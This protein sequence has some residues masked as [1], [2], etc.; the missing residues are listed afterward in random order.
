MM[1]VRALGGLLVFNL[2][3]LG[4]GAGLLWGARGWRWWTDL[5]RLVGVAYLLGLSALMV[6]MTLEIVIGIPVALA[7]ILLNGFG[8]AALGVAAGR[9]RRLPLPGLRPP[10]WRFPGISVFEALFLAGIVVY[11]EG[12]FRADRLAGVAREWD[13]WAF[14]VP[15][16]KELYLSGR[17]GPDF[18]LL[19]EQG[20]SY[21][22][23]LA[24]IQAGAFHAMGSADTATLHVQYW[25]LALG[26]AAAVIGLFAQ[27]VHHAIVFPLLL[28]FLVAPSVLD[29]ITTVYADIP[30]GYLVAVAALLIVLWIEERESWQLAAATVLLS[31]AVLTKREG[32]LFAACLL[33]AAF[34]ASFAHRRQLWRRLFAAG[35]IVL[36]AALPWRIWFLAHDLPG[37]G[38]EAGYLGAFS[39]LERIWPSL[40]FVVATFFDEDLWSFAPVVVAAAIALALLARA[41]TVSLYAGAFLVVALVASGWVFWSNVS[42]GLNQDEW[43]VRRLTGTTLLVLAVLTPLLLQRAWS[44]AQLPRSSAAPLGGD[45]LLGRS[46]MAWAIVLVGVLSHPG[47]MLVGYSGSGLPGGLPSFPESGSCT[48]AP[49]AG[50]NVRVVLGYA[51]SYPEAHAMRRRVRAAGVDGVEMAQDGCGRVRVFVDVGSAADSE[52]LV[53]AVRSANLEPTLEGLGSGHAR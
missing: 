20:S 21:P 13:S 45:A 19:L 41:W 30:L 15:R 49:A 34:V 35:L 3:I 6:L 36:A 14:W 5:V 8:L 37:D 52:A 42:L 39:N 27:R 24:T 18:L 10:G 23:G 12:L 32:V 48:S 51:G 11:F 25:F 7:T 22:P 40:R 31:G 33:L 29:W 28:A 46:R 9:L 26:F 43:A 17:L 38:P 1:T 4:V 53:A 47:A 44:P 50:A 2:F 16:A